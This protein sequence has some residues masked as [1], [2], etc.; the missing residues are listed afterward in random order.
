ME[1]ARLCR[2][3]SPNQLRR[4]FID[5]STMLMYQGTMDADGVTG[6]HIPY[7][8]HFRCA[9][10]SVLH[11]GGTAQVVGSYTSLFVYALPY[12]FAEYLR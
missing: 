8:L 4:Q 10:A 11:G 5:F 1:E 3:T 7:C 2:T 12:S 9:T 6:A